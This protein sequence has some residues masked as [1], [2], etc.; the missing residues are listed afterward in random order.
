MKKRTPKLSQSSETKEGK[1]QR[2]M[3]PDEDKY[4]NE[5][6]VEFMTSIKDKTFTDEKTLQADV[7]NK[8]NNI[9]KTNSEFKDEQYEIRCQRDKNPKYLQLRCTQPACKFSCWFS[10]EGIAAYPMKI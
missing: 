5:R 2:V 7:I 10:F 3:I 9:A 1:K 8:L 4:T 6:I